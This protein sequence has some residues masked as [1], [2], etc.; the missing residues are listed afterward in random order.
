M[1]NGKE[2]R[3]KASGFQACVNNLV[4]DNGY[5]QVVSGPT[6]EDALLDIY[7]LRPECFLISFNISPGISEH[8]GV[9]LEVEWDKNCREPK[10]EKIVPFYHKT[11]VLG[12]PAFLRK[13]YKLWAG[14]GSCVEDIW[15]NYKDIIFEG[16]KRCVNQRI[17][18]RIPDREYY[19]KE[20]KRLKVK[21]RKMYNKRKNGQ[22]YQRELKR[23]SMELLVAK[24]KAQETFLRVVLQNEE[25]CWTEF[26]KYV[27]RR[28]GNREIIPAI[29]DHNGKLITD[30]LQK[31][32][33]LNSY[34][35]SLL[36]CKSNN[37]AGNSTNKIR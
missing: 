11:D 28:K 7:L 6:R 8:N 3:K 5:T 15:E 12:L 35:A 1:R 33:F 23:L 16:I 14:N 26:Y 34:Y 25:R 10:V 27:K 20:V 29:K 13:N 19:D 21:V 2:T 17:L 36:G 24:K 9:L 32:N 31:T 22:P 4:W 37:P 30:Q 18:I